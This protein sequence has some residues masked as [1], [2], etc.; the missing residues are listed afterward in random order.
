[1]SASPGDAEVPRAS[2]ARRNVRFASSPIAWQH[3]GVVAAARPGPSDARVPCPLCGGL[4][5]PIAGKCKHCKADLTAYRAARPAANA[6]LPPLTQAPAPP[7]N[8]QATYAPVAH[9]VP[10]LHEVSQPV[11]PPRP[12]GRVPTAPSGSWRSWPVVVIV[13]A[14]MAILAAVV[15][16]VWPAHRDRDGKRLLPPPAPERMDTQTPPV[17]PQIKPS[18]PP[19]AQAAPQNPWSPQPGDPA[20]HPGAAQVDPPDPSDPDDDPGSADDMF[21]ALGSGR[22]RLNSTGQIALAMTAHLCQK[23]ARCSNDQATQTTCDSLLRTP[24]RPPASCPAFGRCLR[25]IDMLDCMPD[26]M[27][28]GMQLLRLGD[29]ADA[30]RC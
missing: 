6:A 1:M 2:Q 18:T 26:L 12:T 23:I 4:I 3:G 7:V 20:H 22:L 13:V 30:M 21:D 9:A 14:M 17:T 10:F 15:L 27:R 29:C 24:A 8:G 5:H 19:A 28:T 16:M 11:L 25:Q